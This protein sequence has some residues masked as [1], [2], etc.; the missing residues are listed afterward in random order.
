M[1]LLFEERAKGQTWD[2]K[3]PHPPAAV[4]AATLKRLYYGSLLPWG[5]LGREWREAL[6]FWTQEFKAW[7]N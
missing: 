2:P 3:D 7:N 6:H 4:R 1:A 5:P